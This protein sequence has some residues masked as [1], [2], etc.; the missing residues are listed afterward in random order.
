MNSRF[1]RT[2]R[3]WSP[4]KRKLQTTHLQSQGSK[5]QRQNQDL[6]IG[7]ILNLR[8]LFQQKLTGLDFEQIVYQGTINTK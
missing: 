2:I 6:N 1:T 5:G 3:E 8:E 7:E 4:S